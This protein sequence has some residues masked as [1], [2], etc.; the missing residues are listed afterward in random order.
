[1]NG[2]LKILSVN[3]EQQ[4]WQKSITLKKTLKDN[5]LNLTLKIIQDVTFTPLCIVIGEQHTAR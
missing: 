5:T 1:M 3:S 4:N 2:T